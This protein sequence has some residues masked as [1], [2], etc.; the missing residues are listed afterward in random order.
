MMIQ[1]RSIITSFILL[2][3]SRRRRGGVCSSLSSSL[4]LESL[5]SKARQVR[6]LHGPDEARPFYQEI[7]LRNQN[8]HTAATLIGADPKAMDHHNQ[9]GRLGT[10]E[11]RRRFVELLQSINYH[12]IAIADLIFSN[13]S[14]DDGQ[15]KVV[16][17]KAK[18]SSAPLYL[19]PLR[20][21]YPCPPLPS[22]A[23]GVCIQLLLLAVSIPIETCKHLLGDE[24]VYLIEELGIAFPLDDNQQQQKQLLV[25]YC[26]IMPVTVQ[27]DE[28]STRR[29]RRTMYIATDLHPNVLSITKFHPPTTIGRTSPDQP[30]LDDK[31]SPVMYIGPDSLALVDHWC[32]LQSPS[33]H[34]TIVDVG[35]GSGIQALTLAARCQQ[36]NVDDDVALPVIKCVDINPRALRL[37]KLNFEWN[38]FTVPDMFIGNII[39]GVGRRFESTDE[40][41]RPLQS[42]TD[43][44]GTPSTTFLVSNPPFLP[45]PID[46]PVISERY[47][48]FSSGGSSGEVFL[49]NLVALASEILATDEDSS[50]TMAIVSEFMN[51]NRDF[52]Q[53]LEGWWSRSKNNQSNRRL[54]AKAILFTNQDAVD[55]ATYAQRRADS[56]IET[57]RWKEHLANERITSISPGFLFLKCRGRV[58]DN[59]SD[60]D[61]DD[62]AHV[63]VPLSSSTTN[64]VDFVHCLVPKTDE[65]SIWTP[66]NLYCRKITQQILRDNSFLQ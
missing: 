15:N 51:P 9:L 52:H 8:D 26:H 7:V 17:S 19:Q 6:V 61:C 65:G 57:I 37:T 12:P 47:G 31:E 13:R 66:H 34:D 49:K 36:Q 21:G 20:A 32:T 38:G 29:R 55:S 30:I 33:G 22:C 60:D 11:Q 54:R 56:P 35:T 16:V 41:T 50:S 46:D 40:T 63:T 62:S 24:L 39:E 10:I 28:R 58:M 64:I 44:L 14:S 1:V 2:L 48:L 43:L 25:P 42:W 53:R 5:Y 3:L 4:P 23:L 45:V 59:Q 27:V 18:I